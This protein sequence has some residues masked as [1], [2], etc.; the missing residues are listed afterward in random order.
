[1]IT[2]KQ[3]SDYESQ[4]KLRPQDHAQRDSKKTKNHA[5]REAQLAVAG[6]YEVKVNCSLH[7][8]LN[9]TKGFISLQDYDVP[10][11]EKFASEMQNALLNIT[12]VVKARWPKNCNYTPILIPFE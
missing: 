11:L 1:M 5:Q 10:R 12:D 9:S 3:G 6:I 7:E 2:E 4:T 8:K